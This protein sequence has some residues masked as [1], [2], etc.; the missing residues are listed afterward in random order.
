MKLPGFLIIGA[1][2]SG[3]TT[4]YRDLLPNPAVFM[5][6]DKEPSNLNT[7]DVLTPQGLKRYAELF[8]SKRPD[9]VGGEASTSYTK[10]PTVT[11][12]PGRA[13]RVLGADV[14]LV[15]LL[16]E[17]VSRAISHH[18]H[19][20]T[21][22]DT[23]DPDINRDIRAKEKY[24]D[25]SRYAM[26]AEAWLDVFGPERLMFVRFESFVK[27]RKGTIEGISRFIGVEPR[28]DLVKEDEVYNKT[29]ERVRSVGLGSRIAA[30]RAYKKLVR[31]VLSVEF[32]SRFR[33][34]VLPK[35]DVKP[36]APTAE[37][38]DWM[39]E[40]LAPDTDRLAGLMG[41]AGP[42]WDVAAVRARYAPGSAPSQGRESA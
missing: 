21:T 11:G 25:Y 33:G 19:A 8:A 39:I 42:V 5:P 37:T 18:A 40:R 10:I 6:L 16:R 22:G 36:V 15:Y 29:S 38:I 26:Q 3:T 30:S 2:K 27:D 4:L 14:R 20:L 34:M 7:D 35:A 13:R 32:R 1:M 9:Q 31:P 24:L 28:P 23:M 41:R 12:V 17:P